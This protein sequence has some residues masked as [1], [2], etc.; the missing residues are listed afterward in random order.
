MPLAGHKSLKKS[1]LMV[2]RYNYTLHSNR[3]AAWIGYYQLLPEIIRYFPYSFKIHELPGG[4]KCMEIMARSMA[5]Q[6]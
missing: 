4:K 2:Q 5:V 6:K 1:L 3:V